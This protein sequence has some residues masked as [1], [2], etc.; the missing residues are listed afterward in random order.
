[1]KEKKSDNTEK[2]DEN[3]KMVEAYYK[4]TMRILEYYVLVCF[5]LITFM[6]L[7]NFAWIPGFIKFVYFTGFPLLI[8]IFIISLFKEPIIKMI[9]N[10]LEK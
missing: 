10:L 7:L 2:K 6:P 8:L 4:K 5:I 3:K 9:T 1:M